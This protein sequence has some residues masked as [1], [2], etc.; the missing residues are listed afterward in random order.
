MGVPKFFRYISERYPCLLEIV[1]E[2]Q[3]PAFDNLYLDMNGIIHMCSHP[4]DNDPHFRITEEK[5]F[6]SIFHYIEILFSMIKPQK[7][8]FM[9]VDG[10]APRAKMNQQR[11]RRFRT[12]KDAEKMEKKALEKGE[13][14]PTES[15]FDSNCI[16]PGTVFMAN[17]QEQLKYFVINKITNDNLWRKCKIILS[18]P[19]TPGEG[20]HKIMDYI[21]YI[22]SQPGYDPNTRHCL[23]GLDA[24]L[25]MLGLCTHEPHFSLLREEVRFGKSSNRR[26]DAPEQTTFFLL[27]L[28]LM[29]E[30]LEL[31]FSQLKTSLPFDFNIENIIDDW[32][33][34]GFLVG[35][36][37]IPNLPNL[38]INKGALS[39][40]YTAYI[41]VLPT[42]DGYINESGQL[43]LERF[44]K[45]MAALCTIDMDH[46]TEQYTD[47][48]FFESKTGRRP[49]LKERTSYKR[50]DLEA[51]KPDE[52]DESLQFEAI[53]PEPE[54]PVNKDL[55]NMI[56]AV[57]DMMLEDSPNGDTEF[58][59]EEEDITESSVMSEEEDLFDMEFRQH[60]EGYYLNKLAY[61]KVTPD[62]MRSQ[63][64]GYV[65]AVQWN[66]NYYYNGVCSWGW[67]YPHHYSPFIS[68]IK[69]FKDLKIEFDLGKPFQPYEQLLA[70]LPSAS[71]KLLPESYHRLMVDTE[72]DIKHY[73]PE[74]F[75]TDLNGKKQDWEAVVLIPFIEEDVLLKAMDPCNKLLSEQ[76]IKRNTHGPMLV[77]EYSQSDNGSYEAP[78]YFPVIMNHHASWNLLTINDIRVPKE[79][80]IKGA[81]PGAKMDV[82][83][84]GFPTLKHLK[85]FGNLSKAKVKVFEQ[86]SREENMVIKLENEITDS[87]DVVAEELLGKIVF[88]GWPHLVEAKVVA[89]SNKEAKYKASDLPGKF[90]IEQLNGNIAQNWQVD[91][92]TIVDHYMYRL[93][94]NVGKT[95]ILVHVTEMIGRQYVFT[96]IGRVN[97]EKKFSTK[98]SV[99][100][101]QTVIKDISV[102]D[103]CN[104]T[105]VNIDDVF[106]ID[107][108]CFMIGQQYYGSIATVKNSQECIG[109]GR[110]KISLKATN[111]PN[112]NKALSLEKNINV[113]YMPFYTA[114]N[115]VGISKYLFTRITGTLFVI[116]GSKNSWSKD[117]VSK[118]NIGLNLKFNKKNEEVPGYTKKENTWLYSNKAV[119]LVR[120]Y[121]QKYPKLFKFLAGHPNDDVYFEA[122]LFPEDK[123][124]GATVKEIAAWLKKQHYYSIDHKICGSRTLEPEVVK[125]LEKIVDKFVEKVYEEKNILMQVKPHLLYKPEFQ[126]G[127]LEADPTTTYELYDRVVNIRESYTVPLGHTGTVIAIHKPKSDKPE[128]FMYDVMFDKAFAGG[129]ALNC[130]S[131]RGY[132]M[133]RTALINKS[134]GMRYFDDNSGNNSGVGVHHQQH[135]QQKQ[136]A[137]GYPTGPKFPDAFRSM[138]PQPQPPVS[139]GPPQKP[140]PPVSYG[141]PQPQPPVYQPQQPQPPVYQP[142]QPQPPVYPP[143]PQ[144]SA[145][146]SWNG[147]YQPPLVNNF[148]N[149]CGAP[150]ML[151]PKFQPSQQQ[152]HLSPMIRPT[153]TDTKPDNKNK[154]NDLQS[155]EYLK[156]MLKIKD[157]D[158]QSGPKID[159]PYSV[160]DI[161]AQVS[162]AMQQLPNMSHAKPVAKSYSLQLLS[163]YQSKGLGCPYYKYFDTPTGKNF[164][165]QL[166]LPFNGEPVFGEA[167]PSREL[168][169]ENVAKAVLNKL[170]SGD[171]SAP[172]AVN[173]PMKFPTPPKQWC[174]TQNRNSTHKSVTYKNQTRN[175]TEDAKCNKFVPLQAVRRQPKPSHSNDNQSANK[176]GGND[177]QSDSSNAKG[178]SRPG[179]KENASNHPG[180]DSK[181]RRQRKM[182]IAA[183][184]SGPSNPHQSNQ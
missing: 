183:N 87:I 68:D 141:P 79:K 9:A 164:V 172:H 11:G 124:T 156:K 43:N 19:E 107:S 82:Y 151:P 48:K 45:F 40:L 66:L 22:R 61:E 24:D 28:S 119:D 145:F 133:S 56:K 2:Y 62:V 178:Q 174:E 49:N 23:Y 32:V 35:N 136:Q 177:N 180:N 176:K 53:E 122:D 102:H 116:M 129:M 126:S 20:E 123:A 155:S 98:W 30:Y 75:A 18:G 89:V 57:D 118:I 131:N 76:E 36:D 162:A 93:G 77:F 33:L 154:Q 81:Y 109:K 179:K 25:I 158:Q 115:R 65:I 83:Y 153:S 7:V 58:E 170:N 165:A 42:M 142:Q 128:D 41:N 29:R 70:V 147:Y 148:M 88:V 26:K 96:K 90:I 51:W 152:Q 184:F 71:K 114:A 106:P 60:K 112:F 91:K 99:F 72:S 175:K 50:K 95:D 120:E 159:N 144:N 15:R 100:P 44:E 94:I 97:V 160:P 17:L 63:A 55:A 149:F 171:Q 31:E 166:V 163:Y 146:V 21:R 86:N 54:K 12:A 161:H 74:D 80:L 137:V 182:R 13:T 85:Y 117:D 139:Y 157:N 92:S 105:Y 4:D 132:R 135:Q 84:P 108:T 64:E 78:E 47:L 111:E 39:T 181:P 34:M 5:I 27:H 104:S 16:T 1:K 37:F 125:E 46:F 59:L 130:S 67:Y 140:Q 69:D 10:V 173:L 101:L 38:H 121:T 3:I 167:A 138:Q 73:Y 110:I 52:E 127:S 169:C 8:F 143:P 168:A 14:L 150:L 134:H 103:E 113:K 6:Q